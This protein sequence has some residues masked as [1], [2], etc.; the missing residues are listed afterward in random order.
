LAGSLGELVEDGVDPVIGCANGDDAV[1]VT[2]GADRVDRPG[3]GYVDWWRNVRHGVEFRAIELE[4]APLVAN[5][6]SGKQFPDDL[7][8][9]E[10]HLRTSATFRP[11]VSH[12]VLVQRLAGT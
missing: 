11:D 12:D 2:T 8:G 6:I 7:D 1:G 5:H 3:S 9:F 4:I 10:H